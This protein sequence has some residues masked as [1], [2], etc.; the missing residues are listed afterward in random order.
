MN[1][2]SVFQYVNVI[3]FEVDICKD[4]GGR[5]QR[6]PHICIMLYKMYYFFVDSIIKV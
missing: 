5:A 4:S 6:R 2:H 1:V 3:I